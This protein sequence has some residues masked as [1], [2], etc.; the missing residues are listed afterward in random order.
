M[1]VDHYYSLYRRVLI[2]I[3]F[4]GNIFDLDTDKVEFIYGFSEKSE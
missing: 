1:L 2:N 3:L 4:F